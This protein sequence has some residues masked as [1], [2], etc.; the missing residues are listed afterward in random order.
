MEESL[1]ALL[2]RN[3][4]FV[5]DGFSVKLSSEQSAWDRC[6]RALGRNRAYQLMAA[7]LCGEYERRFGAPFL[8]SERC[9]AWELKYHIDA[10]MAV[11]GYRGYRRHVSTLLFSPEQLRRHCEQVDISTED[12]ASVK[13]RLM[14]GYRQGIRP[15]WKGT[16]QDP[17]RK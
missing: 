16:E 17:F 5:E 10:Y 11:Q 4:S 13:Q 8:F 1:Q 2:K 9:V 15:C 6:F 7:A 3:T 14:F 12:V